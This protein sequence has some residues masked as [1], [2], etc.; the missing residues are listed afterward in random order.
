MRP[1][2]FIAVYCSA[3]RAW[4]PRSQ[5]RRS[6]SLHD[7]FSGEHARILE[8]AAHGLPQ[9]SI[10]AED[11]ARSGSGSG[12]IVNNGCSIAGGENSSR[13]SAVAAVSLAIASSMLCPATWCQSLG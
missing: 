11:Y 1:R 13:N 3:L 12:K 10:L 4:E 7:Y 9:H 2:R 8:V 5:P 6:A